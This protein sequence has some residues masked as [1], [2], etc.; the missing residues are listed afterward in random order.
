MCR[1]V[2]APSKK[3]GQYVFVSYTRAQFQT[4]LQEEIDPWDP[5][6][7]HKE[8]HIRSRMAAL[9]QGNLD[10]LYQVGILAAREAE[11]LLDPRLF[12]MTPLIGGLE[13]HRI[14]DIARGAN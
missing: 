12:C 11:R 4:Y 14:C 2:I 8:A 7:N 1:T 3:S 10:Q 13:T 5:Q 9:R 6:K